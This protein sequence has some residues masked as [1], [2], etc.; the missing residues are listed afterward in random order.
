MKKQ[1]F[2]AFEYDGD[3]GTASIF[4]YTESK[5]TV[6]S[7][8]PKPMW[9]VYSELEVEERNYQPNGLS[10]ISVSDI[11]NKTPYF[12]KCID[13]VQEKNKTFAILI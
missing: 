2:L 13:N 3:K 5:I 12:Q 10:H 11:D 7:L 9:T 6:E 4:V 8:L 1:K